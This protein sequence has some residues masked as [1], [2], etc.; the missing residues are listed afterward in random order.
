MTRSNYDQAT[1]KLG[2]L[3]FSERTSFLDGPTT[4]LMALAYATLAAIDANQARDE[5][6]KAVD[7]RQALSAR[8]SSSPS[9]TAQK[10]DPTS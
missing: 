9:V 10:Q 1:R 7:G 4:A 8:K 2:E 5:A 3:E 6:P